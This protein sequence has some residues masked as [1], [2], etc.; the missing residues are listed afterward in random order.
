ML[1]DS[2]EAARDLRPHSMSFPFSLRSLLKIIGLFFLLV[3]VSLVGL[4][5]YVKYRQAAYASLTNSHDLEKRTGALLSDY[6]LK[7]PHAAVSVVLFSEGGLHTIFH[8]QVKAGSVVRPDEK[9]LFEIGSVTKV[10]TDLLL[11]RLSQSGVV[12]LNDPVSR[13]FPGGASAPEKNGRA[14]T[15]LDLGI[16]TSGLPRL[17]PNLKTSAPDPYAHY[18]SANLYASFVGLSLESTPGTHFLYSNFGIGLLGDVLSRAAGR[19]YEELI[20]QQICGPLGMTDT[21]CVLTKEQALRMVEEYKGDNSVQPAWN[22]DVLAP[23]GGLKS[24]AADL[25]KFLIALINEKGDSPL[26]SALPILYQDR[27]VHLTK[28]QTLGWSVRKTLEK[29]TIYWHNGATAGGTAYLAVD[30][31]HHC[32]VALL[33]N[34]GDALAADFSLDTIGASLLKQATKISWN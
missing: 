27:F 9:T 34:Y 4:F 18:T 13:Y 23:A 19:T 12:H 1:R 31:Q 11:I 15:L 2:L 8:G 10:F 24:S 33:S 22:F 21:R 7:R 16:H 29:Q 6:C 20:D 25:G 26:S 30:L 5:A 3:A 28:R 17:P 14:I 32:G